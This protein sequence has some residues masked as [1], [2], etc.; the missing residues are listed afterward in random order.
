MTAKIKANQVAVGQYYVSKT[1]IFVR[2]IVQEGDCEYILWR[3]YQLD[4]GEPISTRPSRCLKQ[5]IAQWAGRIATSEEVARMR[6]D[7]AI[8]NERL[9]ATMTVRMALHDASDEELLSE[10]RRRGLNLE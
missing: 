10:V 3:D 7:E 1:E 9:H 5:T 2:E 8:S 6:K 4:T